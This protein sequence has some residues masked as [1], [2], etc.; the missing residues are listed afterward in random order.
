[1]T[2]LVALAASWQGASGQSFTYTAPINQKSGSP[3]ELTDF[4]S[5][6]QN[7]ESFPVNFWVELHSEA[8]SGWMLQF[9]TTP[10][11]CLPPWITLDTTVVVAGGGFDSV[12]VHIYP[13]S[14]SLDGCAYMVVHPAGHPELGDTL[15]FYVFVPGA[16]LD[17]TYEAPIVEKPG[18]PGQLTQFYSEISSLENY[19]FTYWIEMHT[20]VPPGW[21]VNF[22]TGAVCWPPWVTLDS[23]LMIWNN[24][25]DSVLVDIYPDSVGT[26][27]WVTMVVYPEGHPDVADSITFYAY[28]PDGIE[29]S[30][31]APVTHELLMAYPNPFNPSVKIAFSTLKPGYA[32]LAI[33]D[34][35]GRLVNR[36]LSGL[37][38]AGQHQ[39]SWRPEG[40]AAGIY[41]ARLSLEGAATTRKIIYLR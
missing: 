9:C 39:I 4:Y 7:L 31:A 12:L 23:T 18:Q 32:E 22:C 28:V 14:V 40:E 2:A 34:L 30:V 20:D 24:G 11:G 16:T 10:S 8:P 25:M 38:S 35:S 37:V 13:D 36:L 29:G 33:Y 17:F 6:I 21:N 27:G 26:E 3:S 19:P 15:F 41:L 5:E 1:M